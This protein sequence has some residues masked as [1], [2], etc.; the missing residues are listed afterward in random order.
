MTT[1]RMRRVYTHPDGF[2]LPNVNT[3]LVSSRIILIIHST[4]F[5]QLFFCFQRL[6][7]GSFVSS[8]HIIY[9]L[10]LYDVGWSDVQ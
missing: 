1:S 8:K 3:P 5:D 7:D 4:T 9:S 10:L 2:D 6:N